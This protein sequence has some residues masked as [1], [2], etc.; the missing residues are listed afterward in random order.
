M[1]KNTKE[2]LVKELQE[3]QAEYQ[4]SIDEIQIRL[5]ELTGVSETEPPINLTG[6]YFVT[7]DL[8]Q[9]GNIFAIRYGDKVYGYE[10]LETD[11]MDND[12]IYD[13]CQVFMTD[14]EILSDFTEI[15][16]EEFDALILKF[17]RWEVGLCKEIE[18]IKQN[19][20]DNFI[21]DVMLLAN[22]KVG[23]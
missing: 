18:N 10:L 13:E 4:N 9:H 16:V 19:L 11:M 15:T 14:E 1:E 3:K 22:S 12:N 6:K 5:N 23:N 7:K 8:K 17:T 21:G 20:Y 2:F